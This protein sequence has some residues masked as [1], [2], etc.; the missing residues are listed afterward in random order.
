MISLTKHAR[1]TLDTHV[2]VGLP[3]VNLLPPEIIAR[4]ALRKVQG[5][6]GLVVL[7]AVAVV[8]LLAHQAAGSV[9]S[10]QDRVTA[11]SSQQAALQAETARYAGVTAAFARTAAVQQMLATAMGPEVR[12]SR[13][14][15]D[16]ALSLPPNVWLTTATWNQPETASTGAAA[17]AGTAGSATSLGTVTFGGMAL[18]HDDV[19]VWL[20]TLSKE[21][22]YVNAYLTSSTEGLIG[23]RPAVTWTATVDLDSNALSGRY[24]SAGQ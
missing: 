16:L 9:S 8:G 21:K 18:S 19:A 6:L 22:G 10:A 17:A 1:P 7:A 24:V 5:G 23:T 13:F 2:V 4:T 3:Q 20:E 14:L 15:N 11:A 12:Y